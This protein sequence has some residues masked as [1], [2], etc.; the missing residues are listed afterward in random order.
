METTSSP[1]SEVLQL[2]QTVAKATIAFYQFLP[3]EGDLEACR[4][5]LLE[6]LITLGGVTNT[7]KALVDDG[8]KR[9]DS[10]DHV[11]RMKN[12]E[13]LWVPDGLVSKCNERMDSLLADFN[14]ALKENP[15]T[16]KKAPWPMQEAAMK[17][18]IENLQQYKKVITAALYA[19]FCES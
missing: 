15:D 11:E 5:K 9:Q 19:D 8:N 13:T 12:I 18:E 3:L 14:K 2:I 1:P 6:E 7:I 4:R 17:D 10:E 16:D